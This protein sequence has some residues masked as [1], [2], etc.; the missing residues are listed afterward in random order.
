MTVKPN[1]LAKRKS[2]SK[3]DVRARERV[4]YLQAYREGKR[5]HLRQKAVAAR[6]DPL[7]WSQRAISNLRA[8]AKKKKLAFNIAACDIPLPKVCP[9][10][11]IPIVLGGGKRAL[12]HSGSPSV[13]RIDG[14]KGYIGGNVKV[15]SARANRIKMDATPTELRAI[16]D[17]IERECVS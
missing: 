4:A 17:Y 1:T 16:A 13:D 15:I 11:G 12:L 8:R 7:Q 10:L 5:D 3:P 2:R 14:S 9:V 6:R